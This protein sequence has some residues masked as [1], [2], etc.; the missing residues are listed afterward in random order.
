MDTV[1]S[2]GH[3]SDFT[4][5]GP[6]NLICSEDFSEDIQSTGGPLRYISLLIFCDSLGSLNPALKPVIL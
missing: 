3:L 1:I 4:S 2:K 5:P 6:D